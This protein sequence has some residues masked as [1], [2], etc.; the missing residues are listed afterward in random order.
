[1]LRRILPVLSVAVIAAIAYDGWIFYSRWK[2][3]RDGEAAEKAEETRRAQ[4]SIDLLGGTKFRII[5]FYASPRTVRHGEKTELCFGV[6][7]A[8][9]VQILPD[10][11]ELH[12]AVSDCQ[13]ISPLR[14]TQYE[15]AAQDGAGHTL[16][17]KVDV[18]VIP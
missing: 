6:Y 5:N 10:L 14:D 8:K 16:K 15:L 7:G 18:K 9:K 1:M 2:S 3:R 12:P 17:A 4:Q 11:G 13:Q